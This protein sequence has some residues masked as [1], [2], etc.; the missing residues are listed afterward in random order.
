[1][2]EITFNVNGRKVNPNNMKNALENAMLKGFEESIKKSIGYVRC[3]EHNQA[4]KVLVKGRN[5]EN[6]SIEV[7]GCC[8]NIVKKATAKLK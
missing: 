6:L 7:S 2:I 3:S 5:F 8:E 4:P 1:M